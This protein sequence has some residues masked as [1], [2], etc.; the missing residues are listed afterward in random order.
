MPRLPLRINNGFSYRSG[1][2]CRN[3]ERSY[4]RQIGRV[5]QVGPPSALSEISRPR[6]VSTSARLGQ[7]GCCSPVLP[8][9]TGQLPEQLSPSQ[10]YAVT[11]QFPLIQV[12]SRRFL[13]H[14]RTT[15]L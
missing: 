12:S 9:H 15:S 8:G 6:Y 4:D 1:T 13:R 10:E 5:K 11:F 14:W 2:G 7:A 3:S